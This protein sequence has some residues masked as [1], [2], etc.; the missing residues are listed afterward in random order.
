MKCGRQPEGDKVAEFG[1]CPAASDISYDGIYSG[2]CG[3]RICWAVAG[4]FCG[5]GAQ[6]SFADKRGTCLN[7]DFYKFRTLDVS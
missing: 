3:G 1:I 5:G 2:K 7:C 4:T 6:G